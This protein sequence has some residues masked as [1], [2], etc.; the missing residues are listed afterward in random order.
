MQRDGAWDNSTCHYICCGI[1]T[2][3]KSTSNHVAL[4]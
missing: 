1:G 3:R 4:S 2:R